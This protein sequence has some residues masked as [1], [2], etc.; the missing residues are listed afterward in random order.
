MGITAEHTCNFDRFYEH[1]SCNA[2][3]TGEEIGNPIWFF[4]SDEAEDKQIACL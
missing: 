2:F 4:K 3:R 1:V